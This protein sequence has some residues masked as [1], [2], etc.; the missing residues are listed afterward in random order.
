MKKMGLY[1]CK[2]LYII[3]LS[4]YQSLCC[5]RSQGSKLCSKTLAVLRD[6]ILNK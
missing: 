5:A 4:P 6:S 3:L 1:K 2:D